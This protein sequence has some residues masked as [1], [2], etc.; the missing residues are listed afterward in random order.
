MSKTLN[1]GL[2][3]QS[4]RENRYKWKHTSATTAN[5]ATIIY[6][7]LQHS[8][9]LTSLTVIVFTFAFELCVLLYWNYRFQPNNSFQFHSA[10][11][12]C[13]FVLH[14]HSAASWLVEIMLWYVTWCHCQWNQVTSL[15]WWCDCWYKVAGWAVQCACLYSAQIHPNP[16]KLRPFVFLLILILKVVFDA[17]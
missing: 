12:V 14:T 4:G 17:L 7:V 5:H 8:Y 11:Y 16:E 2:Q 10:P 1:V 13:I 9:T 15:Y 3:L 6:R